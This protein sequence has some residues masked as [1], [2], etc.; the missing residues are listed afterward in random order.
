MNDYENHE[1]NNGYGYEV[2]EDDGYFAPREVKIIREVVE[3]DTR[4]PEEKAEQ[5]AVLDRAKHFNP[6]ANKQIRPDAIISEHKRK[7]RNKIRAREMVNKE[8]I[9]LF[10]ENN[11]PLNTS[12]GMYSTAEMMDTLCHESISV[13]NEPLVYMMAAAGI[14]FNEISDELNLGITADIKTQEELDELQDMLATE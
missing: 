3:M 7:V 8:T 14:P 6:M 11:I 12:L 2:P 9:E 13:D 4:T 10:Q 5:A 1:L